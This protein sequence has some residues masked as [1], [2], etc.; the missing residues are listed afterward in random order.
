MNTLAAGNP[1]RGTTGGGKTSHLTFYRLMDFPIHIDA[2]SMGLPI[3]YFKGLQV[4]V[5]KL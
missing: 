4:E 1:P 2:I 5:S 3:L